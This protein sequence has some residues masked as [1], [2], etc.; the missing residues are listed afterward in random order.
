MDQDLRMEDKGVINSSFID[1]V[2]FLEAVIQGG[3]GRHSQAIF[4][5]ACDSSI[6]VLTP[7]RSRQR[8]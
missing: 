2:P 4:M 1:R 6:V 7:G 8:R 5:R 3:K